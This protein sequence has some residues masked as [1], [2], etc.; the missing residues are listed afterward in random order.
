MSGDH[1]RVQ[2]LRAAPRACELVLGVERVL[3]VDARQPIRAEFRFDPADPLTVS[4]EFI[5]HGG[6]RVLWRIGRD[7]LAQGLHAVSGLGDVQMWPSHPQERATARLRLSAGD[8]A[9]L[10]DLPVPPLEQWLAHTYDLVPAGAELA[11]VDWDMAGAELLD[12][13]EPFGGRDLAGER[14]LSDDQEW[15]SE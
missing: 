11:A 15:R 13:Q 10:F 3:D 8:M 5:V 2:A 14:R 4:V 7:L 9:A 6:P 12:G 1:P